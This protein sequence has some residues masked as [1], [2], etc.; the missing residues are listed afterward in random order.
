MA[1][2]LPP[3][4]V[5]LPGM[6]GTGTLFQP[7]LDALGPNTPVQVL[8][9]PSDRALDYPAL[10]ERVWQQIPRERPFVLLGESFSGPIAVGIAARRPT[11]LI[12]L[13]LCSSFVRNP[14]PALA[15]LAP[16]LKFMPW[17]YL[18]SWPM[19]A[20]LLGG[21]STPTLRNMLITAVARVAPAV[22]RLRL[23]EVIGVDR[24]QALAAL[25]VPLLYLR[26][27][28][29]RLVPPQASALIQQLRQDVHLIEVDAPHCLLQAE[30]VKA[31]AHLRQF[32]Q[33]LQ[34]TGHDWQSSTG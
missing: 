7:L 16:L 6:D 4:L 1:A 18:P 29:D 12:G 9:Y 17:Q 22:L 2:T 33:M 8:D 21:F 14:R 10:E 25:E 28:E 34:Q 27:R 23:R 3:M 30:P 19:D 31:A 11:G 26:A 13:V 24:C 20:L 15:P 32:M 5:L